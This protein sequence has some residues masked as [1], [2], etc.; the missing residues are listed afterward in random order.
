MDSWQVLEAMRFGPAAPRSFPGGADLR[1]QIYS[2]PLVS[3]CAVE[4]ELV[5]QGY[6]SPSF[7]SSLVNRRGLAALEYLLFYEGGNTAC[8]SSS[9]IVS[10]GGWAALEAAERAGRK[11]SYA[12]AVAD[13]VRSRA[14]ALTDAWEPSVGNFVGTLETSADGN[15]VFSSSQ[16]ALNAVSDGLFYLEKEVKD[17]KLAPPLGLR[18][19][20]AT[21]CPELLESQ[22]A[23]RSKANIRANLEGFRRIAEG[24]GPGHTGL[25]FDDLL[26]SVNAAQVSQR[27]RDRIADAE[28]ALDAIEEPDLAPPLASDRASVLALHDG[29]KGISDLMKTEFITVL[30]LEIPMS[31]EGDND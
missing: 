29:F 20:L 6:G 31:L 26:D 9:P 23:G 5:A 30:D 19:C 11:R 12:A 15:A 7:S 3:R 24:C 21:S 22:Y 1:D 2:W 8:P 28:A 25:G 13:D 16:M 10:G 17:M 14:E 4:E 18:D 27:L